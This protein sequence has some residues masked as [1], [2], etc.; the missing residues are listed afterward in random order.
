MTP[1][2]TEFLFFDHEVLTDGSTYI[3]QTA[4]ASTTVRVYFLS[5]ILCR[6]LSVPFFR[7]LAG[8]CVVLGR[9][10]CR[11]TRASVY[12]RIVSKYVHSGKVKGRRRQV[13]RANNA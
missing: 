9:S 3:P 2:V 4:D 10:I 8:G 12:V 13:P 5:A 7:K 6:F 1:R 11:T